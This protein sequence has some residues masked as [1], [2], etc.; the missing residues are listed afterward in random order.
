MLPQYEEEDDAE[1]AR[2]K[3]RITL[4]KEGDLGLSKDQALQEVREKLAF[5]GKAH[6]SLEVSKVCNLYSH[7]S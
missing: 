6:F 1:I 2:K 3:Q 5:R 7:F 4:S